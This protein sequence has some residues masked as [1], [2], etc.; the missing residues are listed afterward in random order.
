MKVNC[1]HIQAISAHSEDSSQKVLGALGA[2][3]SSCEIA[4]ALGRTSVKERHALGSAGFRI[5]ITNH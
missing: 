4:L 1:W 3:S 5:F 2:I